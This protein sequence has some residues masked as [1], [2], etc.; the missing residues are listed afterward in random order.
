[1]AFSGGVDSTVL[2]HLLQRWCRTQRVAPPLTA[3]HINHGLQSAA[4]EWQ[5]HC[6][7]FCRKLGVPLRCFPASVSAAGRG[8][9]AAA[10]DARYGIFKRQLGS[11]DVLFLGHHLDDQVETF[12]LRLLRGAG[13]QGLAAMPVTRPLGAGRLARPLL[14]LP[15]RQLENHAAEHGLTWVE[16]PSNEDIDLDRNF[17]RAQVLPLLASRWPGYRR[18]VSRAGEHIGDAAALLAQLLPPPATVHSVMGDPGIALAELAADGPRG[19]AP[20]LRHWLQARNLLAPDQAPLDEFLRQ[21]REGGQRSR[22][23]LQCSAFTLKRYRDA[24][25]L[26]PDFDDQSVGESLWLGP[27]EVYELPG[28]GQL[29]LEEAA[30][31]GLS[32]APGERLQVR[33]RRGGERCRPRG[34]PGGSAS[35]KKLLQEWGVPPWWRDRLPL[36][37]LDEELLA[38]GGLWL[39]ESSRLA[40]RAEPGRSLWRPRWW[41]NIPPL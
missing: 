6:E 41:R 27:G 5:L 18:T 16:D 20:K 4:A 35:L 17:L 32:L 15:R 31:T 37:Y 7:S 25:Y 14:G 23:A 29:A 30:A 8:V 21:L 9:E 22:P 40:D 11:G 26:L 19:A 3:I 1:V 28:S 2:L 38:V 39:C 34:R 10:R 33:W 12:F 36:L 13:L 24:V